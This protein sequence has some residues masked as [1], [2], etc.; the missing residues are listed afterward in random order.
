MSIRAVSIILTAL[1]GTAL[2][3]PALR[4]Q[5][6]SQPAVAEPAPTTTD[7]DIIGFKDDDHSR[8][9]IP[10]SIGANGPYAFLIDTGS[11]RTVISRELAQRLELMG[12]GNV[13]VHSMTE[14]RSV[15]TAMIPQL[16]IS[17]KSVKDVK[18]PAFAASHI[19]AAGMLGVDSLK[20]HRIVFDFSNSTLKIVPGKKRP[21][22]WGPDVI[23]VT[24]RNLYGRLILTDARV[25]GEKIIA[26]VDTGS[27]VTVGNEALR[28]KLL[29]KGKLPLTRPVEL[30]DIAGGRTTVDYTFVKQISLAEVG[31]NNM[32]VGFGDVH[33][34]GK[35]GL[36]DRPAILLGMDALRLF[37]RVSVD[38]SRKEV[39]FL[40]P[41][42]SGE[43]GPR[44]STAQ[45][46]PIPLGGS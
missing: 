26:V 6:A 20:S 5:D 40:M 44:Q 27:E 23:V 7:E 2:C 16:Q 3:G 12:G 31:I 28:R 43:L 10:V 35:L 1:A 38:F 34:F 14:T 13:R 32:P 11:E 4:A 18:A 37:Q 42:Q 25:D 33:L 46:D 21:D 29:A 24:G 8:M 9:T 22:N 17:T 30:V 19:G 39:R 45:A 36:Q 41:D 15:A